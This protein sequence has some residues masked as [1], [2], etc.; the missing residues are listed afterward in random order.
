MEVRDARFLLSELL[1][2]ANVA[3]PDMERAVKGAIQL[4]SISAH[5][6]SFSTSLIDGELTVTFRT[7]D[8]PKKFRIDVTE[9]G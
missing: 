5:P 3:D 2:I 4:G 6:E 9:V 1:L 8:G 7:E